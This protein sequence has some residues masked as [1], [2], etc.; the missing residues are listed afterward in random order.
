ML[1]KKRASR[2]IQSPHDCEGELHMHFPFARSRYP[3]ALGPFT[4]EESTS[5]FYAL[6]ATD[7]TWLGLIFWF[8]RKKL[9]G[10]FFKATRRTSLDNTQPKSPYPRQSP[11]PGS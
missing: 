4:K 10:L 3:Q 1:F 9:A 5:W 11:A 8:S 6:F 7:V 2:A